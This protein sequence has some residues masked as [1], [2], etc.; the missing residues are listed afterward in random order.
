MGVYSGLY[1]DNGRLYL[2]KGIVVNKGDIN[3]HMKRINIVLYT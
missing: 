3:L 2:Q 1:A